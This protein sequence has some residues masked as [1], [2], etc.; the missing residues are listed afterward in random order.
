MRTYLFCSG[1]LVLVAALALVSLWPERHAA[2]T[3][4][5][6]SQTQLLSDLYPLY[7]NAVW[8]TSQPESFTV[9]TT[10]YTGES[11]TSSSIHAS[12]DPGSVFTPFQSYYDQKLRALGWHVANDLAAG[13]HVGGQSGYRKGSNVILLRFHIDYQDAPTDAPSTCPCD[14]ALSLF[15]TGQP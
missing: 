2:P 11:I 4:E 7:A 14:V 9:G 10:T 15:S 5:S 3:S 12:M 13:G 1:L 8:S 6:D